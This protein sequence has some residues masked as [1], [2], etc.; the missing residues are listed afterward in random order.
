MGVIA[1][2]LADGIIFGILYYFGKEYAD[3]KSILTTTDMTL[4]FG[5]VMVSGI[6]I[7]GVATF[8]SVNYYLK[9][10]TD[11]LYYV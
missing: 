4:I 9:M 3:L 7:T 2:L 11:S 5:A 8:F 6:V 1:G 10:D